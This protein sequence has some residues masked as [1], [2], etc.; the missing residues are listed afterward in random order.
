MSYSGGS[1]SG[2]SR[3]QGRTGL[4]K[5]LFRGLGEQLMGS[6]AGGGSGLGTPLGI[7]GPIYQNLFGGGAG[8]YLGAKGAIQ[9]TLSGNFGGAV[10]TAYNQLLPST[11][12]G[13]QQGSSALQAA[14]GPAGLRFSTDLMGQ[15]GRLASDLLG[16]TQQQALGAGLNV[17]NQRAQTGQDIFGLIG[18]LGQQNNPLTALLALMG[19]PTVLSTGGATSGG[20]GVDVGGII[21]AMKGVKD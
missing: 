18:Q 4:S 2:E 12:Q 8:D 19:Q 21:K 13:I 1:S 14:A 7:L 3:V 6:L 16:Q 10:N 5:K 20:G 11:L 17:Y 9:D 15:Q